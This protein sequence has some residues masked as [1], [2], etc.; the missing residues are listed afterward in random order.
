MQAIG[1]TKSTN[2]S[3]EIVSGAESE[4]ESSSST[5][6][7]YGSGDEGTTNTDINITQNNTPNKATYE[8]S[9]LSRSIE[10][11]VGLSCPII[12]VS[13]AVPLIY[14]GIQ[15]NN[16]NSETR[17]A[18][19]AAFAVSGLLTVVGLVGSYLVHAKSSD[20]SPQVP[21]A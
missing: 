8:Q 17:N 2:N 20:S 11:I 4:S 12:A 13:S 19:S 9:L 5:E 1:K 21:H 14:F 16:P 7:S 3:S 18:D 10:L 15:L 6:S